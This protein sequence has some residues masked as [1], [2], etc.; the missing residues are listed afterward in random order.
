MIH[1]GDRVVKAFARARRLGVARRLAPARSATTS[2]SPPTGPDR[3]PL[4]ARRRRPPALARAGRRRRALRGW[5][6]RTATTLPAGCRGLP[7]R[8][9]KAW[10]RSS[11]SR[12][13]RN[14][15]P[16][17]FQV[18]LVADSA[19][20]GVLGL[21]GLDRDN[22]S[23]S[24][25]YWLARSAQGRGLMTRRGRAPDRPRLRRARPAPAADPG[26][27]RQP[28]QPR[29]PR[30]ARVHRG[31]PAARRGALRR[32]VPRPGPLLAAGAGVARSRR[33]EL[34]ENLAE[35]VEE[36]PVLVRGPVADAD[37]AGAAQRRPGRTRI[38]RSASAATTSASSRVAERDPGEVRLRVRRLEP[39][40]ADAL[41][42]DHPLDERCARPGRRRRRRGGSPRRRPPGR[43]R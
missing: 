16:T 34:A 42:D 18:A 20:A 25:G 36:A 41:L 27:P 13:P 33:R 39:E 14:V 22:R 10:S 9:G 28:A 5:S 12:S 4:R 11:T 23:T 29:D 1:D 40:L 6:T 3:A 35:G 21:H 31:G 8:P 24:M 19:I 38:P 37:V 43:A 17:G 32:P 26:R 7:G 15:S 30:A 2:T